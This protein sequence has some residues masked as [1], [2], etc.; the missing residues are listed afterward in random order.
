MLRMIKTELWKLRRYYMI[1]AGVLLMLLSVL[2]TVFSTTALDG[3]VWTFSF[4]TEQV[5]KNN[6]TMIFPMCIALIAGYIIAREGK[7]DTLKNLVTIPVSYRNLLW[8]KLL[9]CALL[10]LFLGLVSTGFTVIANLLMG[11][12]G[13]SAAS[14]SQA[15]V[16]I[17]MNCLFLYIA[18]MPIIAVTAR[19]ANGHLIG[20][21]IAFVYGYGGMFAAADR[22]VASLYPVTASLGLIRYRSYDPGVHW[23]GF[24]CLFSII[25]AFFISAIFVFTT[26]TSAPMK[27]NK[28]QKQ[29]ISKKGW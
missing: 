25:T 2:L 21:I 3:T 22:T 24:I 17:I 27:T 8:G 5:I 18:V 14:V 9:V 11:F 19:M 6:V 10:S 16:Q 13:L 28:K 15:F 1:W 26:K 4:F 20:T 23:H 7:D 12:P 29:V